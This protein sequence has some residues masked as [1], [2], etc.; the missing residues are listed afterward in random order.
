MRATVLGSAVAL[1]L[2]GAAPFAQQQP[3]SN[4]TP[5]HNVFVA[6][7]CV[8]AGSD[9]AVASFKLTDA[10]SIGRTASAAAAEP[11]AVGTSGLKASYELQPASGVN[12][13]GKNAD[14][15]KAHLGQRVELVLR[16]VQTTA[17]PPSTTASVGVQA[18]RPIDAPPE[19]FLVTEIK[20]VTGTCS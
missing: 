10:S 1:A 2:W 18:A 7:G 6:T 20:R 4:A 3:A 16:P 11:G 12:A 15:L 8:T 17:A 13:Q 5:A 19:R 14:E 9:R